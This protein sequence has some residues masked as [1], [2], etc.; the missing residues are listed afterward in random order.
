MTKQGYLELMAQQQKIIDA[1][2][3]ERNSIKQEY[4]KSN[5]ACKI[6]DKV[7][8][9]HGRVIEKVDTG[10][11]YSIHARDNGEIEYKA[12]KIKKDG[13][14]SAFDLHIYS[15]KSMKVITQ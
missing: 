2:R 4:I 6:G 13:K 12:H 3:A 7:E 11:I 9:T 15:V 5:A 1:A 10:I 8:F 14:E